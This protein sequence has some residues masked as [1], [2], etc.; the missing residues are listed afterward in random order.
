MKPPNL[1]LLAASAML[2]AACSKP[3]PVEEPVRAVKLMTVQIDHMT[4]GAEFAG[5]V[6]ARVE[7]RLAFRVGGKV[8][9]RPA[10]IGQRV[11]PG[12][13]LA[14]LDVQDFK[15][16]AEA[17]RAQLQVTQT[18]RD[19]AAADVKRYRDLK[20]QNF[21]SGIELDRRE[22][23]YKA[24]AAQVEQMQA[25]LSTLSN[26]SAYTTLIADVAGVVTGVEVEPGQV[27]TAG[28]TIARIAQD[29]ARDVVFSV[30]EDRV[31]LMKLG[32]PV[33]VRKWSDGSRLT[34]SLREV[35][36]LAD[37]VTRTFQVKVALEGS[38]L[39]PLGSTV[40]VLPQVLSAKGQPVIK[41][42][43]SALKQD[44][45]GSAVWVF[46]PASKTLRS[47]A[48]AVLAADGNEAVISQGLEPGMQVVSAGVHVL[49]A[50][51]KV[52]VFR[53]AAAI[54]PASAKAASAP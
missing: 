12:Q 40:T 46:D 21:V 17:M 14:Q 42:P 32:S 25:Q 18:N 30:P 31:M 48:V 33:E 24:A 4:S 34:G 5:E 51:Q 49:Q 1:A 7:S 26:Q 2:L 6:R 22:A 45:K 47:Q 29:G 53:T 36:A 27:V 16:A 8:T 38:E 15:L 54:A 3:V 11:R 20:E 50:G 39:L 43:T 10:E 35:A 52:S 9:R 44:G 19:L 28:A 37:P 41:L 13:T 23:T